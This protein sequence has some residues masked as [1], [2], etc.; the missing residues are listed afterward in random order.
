MKTA[1]I[2]TLL[3][4]CASVAHIPLAV[5]LLVGAVLVALN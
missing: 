1:V 5:S 3:V 2:A 4:G